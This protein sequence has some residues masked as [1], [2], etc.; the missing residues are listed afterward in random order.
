MVTD[1]PRMVYADPKSAETSGG[2]PQSASELDHDARSHPDTEPTR[3]NGAP[4]EQRDR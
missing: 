2:E 3:T 1:T 4:S